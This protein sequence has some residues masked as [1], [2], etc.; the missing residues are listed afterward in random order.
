MGGFLFIMPKIKVDPNKCIGCGICATTCPD[1]FKM[2]EDKAIVIKP[3]L[4]EIKEEHRE[5]VE[6][7]PVDAISI[8]EY[9]V[10]VISIEE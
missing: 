10:N 8:E 1:V 4:D 6:T 7:C 2:L 3:D 9:P 5:S